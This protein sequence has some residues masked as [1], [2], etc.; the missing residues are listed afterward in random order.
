MVTMVIKMAESTRLNQTQL[1]KA[2]GTSYT[3]LWRIISLNKKKARKLHLPK[4]P[5][6][7]LYP[8]GRKY[9]YLEEFKQWLKVVSQ[10]DA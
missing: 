1:A 8:G 6:H 4:C 3:T 10:F 7:S 5:E 2:L 9:F